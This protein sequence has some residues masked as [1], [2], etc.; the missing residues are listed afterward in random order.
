ME[1]IGLAGGGPYTLA[2]AAAMPDRVIAVGILG[3]AA[4]T[5]GF[6]GIGGGVMGRSDCRSPRFWNTSAAR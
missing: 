6:D 3:G 5:R 2:C 1:I 4:P